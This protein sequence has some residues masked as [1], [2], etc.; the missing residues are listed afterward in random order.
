M[1]RTD[2]STAGIGSVDGAGAKKARDAMNAD[3][4]R[5]DIERTREGLGET[6]EGLAAK[7]DVKARAR[8]LVMAIGVRRLL[9]GAGSAA[10]AAGGVW[11]ASKGA[12]AFKARRARSRGIRRFLP[13]T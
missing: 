13:S 8:R 11:G 4:L 10:V 5:E 12:R 3:E 2:T 7:V 6:V 1:R 9:V